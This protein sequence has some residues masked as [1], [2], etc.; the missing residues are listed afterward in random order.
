M[1][2]PL[3]NLNFKAI[4]FEVK[5]FGYFAYIMWHQRRTLKLWKFWL[6]IHPSSSS[7][8]GNISKQNLILLFFI[9]SRFFLAHACILDNID[10]EQM[11]KDTEEACSTYS[12][13]N[14]GNNLRIK[15]MMEKFCAARCMAVT[16]KN[17]CIQ[18]FTSCW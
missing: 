1:W 2:K 4:N 8:C 13:F 6:W 9:T 10:Y 11:R 14:I 17:L 18:Y 12:R 5:N 7:M 3:E 16:Y 15:N